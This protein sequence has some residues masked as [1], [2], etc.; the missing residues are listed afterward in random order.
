MLYDQ[1]KKGRGGLKDK[2]GSYLLAC[3]PA[4]E[5]VALGS[6]RDMTVRTRKLQN[7]YD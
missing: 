2:C 4:R 1:D 6:G 3:E 5:A 7:N